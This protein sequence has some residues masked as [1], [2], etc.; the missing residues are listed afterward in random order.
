[1]KEE[2]LWRDVTS[3]RVF[4]LLLLAMLVVYVVGFTVYMVS[5]VPAEIR[6][7]SA[8][9][10]KSSIAGW[11]FLAQ[12]TLLTLIYFSILYNLYALLVMVAKGEPFHPSNPKR[13]R[14]I[15]YAAFA[16]FCVNVAAA[17]LL[18][19]SGFPPHPAWSA[20]FSEL[21]GKG[22]RTVLFGVGILVIAR[23]FEA[24]LALKQD[25]DLTV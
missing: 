17:V 25:Q 7:L 12:N 22:F 20:L 2:K 6:Q 23:V 21:L 1:M 11:S 5:Q 4:K 19:R 13:I 14:R 16:I 18:A 10:G 24:G 15:A 9:P 8:Q 3:V